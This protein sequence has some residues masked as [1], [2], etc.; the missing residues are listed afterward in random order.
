MNHVA[1]WADLSTGDVVLWLLPLAVLAVSLLA[2]GRR[3]AV[4]SAASV[5]IALPLIPDHNVPWVM[6]GA[7][8]GLWIVVATI[9]LMAR[10]PAQRWVGKPSGFESGAVGLMLGVALLALLLAAIVR[11][12]LPIEFGLRSALGLSFLAFGLLHLMLRRDSMRAVVAFAA[13]GLGIQWLDWSA[14]DVLLPF[15]RRDPWITLLAT[16]VAVGLMTRIAYA[17]QREAG[18]SWVSDAHDLHD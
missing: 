4:A 12:R 10:A 7:W 17:R 5:A 18:S 3:A 9:L 2:P 1:T 6:I 15:E 8:T 16:A 11:Q 13:L 14:R